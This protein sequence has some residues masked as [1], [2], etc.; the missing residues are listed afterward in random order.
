M[1]LIGYF[2]WFWLFIF[3]RKFRNIWIGELKSE[4]WIS[5]FFS[6][7]EAISSVLVGLI[8]PIYLIYYFLKS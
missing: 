3:S 7:L 5:R 8:G 4:N 6:L 1:E 2:A